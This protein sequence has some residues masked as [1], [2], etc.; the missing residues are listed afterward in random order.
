MDLEPKRIA[1]GDRTNVVLGRGLGAFSIGLG[2]AELAAP[3][4]LARWIGIDDCGAPVPILR[5][6]GA[7]EALAGIG[8][9]AK[10]QAAVGPW[11][12]VLG[13]AIDLAFLTWAFDQKSV[14]RR[15]TAFVIAAVVGVAALDLFAAIRRRRMWFG[16]P[17]RRTITIDRAPREAYSFWRDLER[18]PEYMQWVESVTDLGGGRSHWKVCTPAGVS[19]EYDAEIIEDIPGQRIS[20]RTLP[21]SKI[22]QRGQVMFAPAIGGRGTDVFLDLQV[23]APLAKT[24]SSE[25]AKQDL[26]NFKEVVEAQA[27]ADASVAGMPAV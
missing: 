18:A 23:N 21:G 17:V 10:P 7:R 25:M 14:R 6:F 8:L 27:D 4:A 19:L 16:E 5:A 13:D 1:E 3:R 26:A 24:I 12:R 11:A 9:L 2:L 22:A 20:W 15:R